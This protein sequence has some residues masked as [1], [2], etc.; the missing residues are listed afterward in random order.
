MKLFPVILLFVSLMSF[1]QSGSAWHH[2]RGNNILNGVSQSTFSPPIRLLWKFKTGD[3]IKS[4]PIIAENK[5]FVG[6]MD[7]NLY[8]LDLKGKLLWKFKTEA[9]IEAPPLYYRGTIV[10]GSMDGTV[11]AIN[12][13]TGK[14]KWKFV[15]GG[16]ITGGANWMTDGTGL[17]LLVPSYDYNL[18]CLNFETGKQRWKAETNNYLNGSAATD[19]RKVTIGGCD[20]YLHIIDARNGKSLAKI[21]IGTYVAEST[22]IS[23]NLA[24]AGDYDGG[25]TCVD[26][27]TYKKVWKFENPKMTPFLSSPAISGNRVVIGSHDRKVYCFNKQDGK[28]LWSYTTFGKID[29][30]PVI[31]R[32]QV[33]IG[34]N[35][36]ILHFINLQT[37]KKIYSY[38]IGVAMK[39]TPAITNSLMITGG[40]DGYLYAFKGK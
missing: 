39:S 19:N 31:L 3:E 7:G 22:A 32:N 17:L 13:S 25:F 36:G 4:S 2:Y 16:Q 18:Y 10:V 34:S 15:T 33:V 38:E 23:G 14:L 37:G 9:S 20:S 28:I 21:D 35:D 40:K 1:G 29:S 8:T 11:Y 26:I 24:F 6:S 27:N 5:V 30:S 12:A